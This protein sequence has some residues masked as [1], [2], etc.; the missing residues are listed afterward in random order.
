MMNGPSAYASRKMDMSRYCS[1][2]D[3]I[4]NSCAMVGSAGATMVD[5][6]GE[7]NVKHETKSVETHF[8]DRLQLRGFDGSS[9]PDQV[10]Y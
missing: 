2:S 5:D 7:M 9:G 3:L 10:T 1:M 6:T 4:P 8:L